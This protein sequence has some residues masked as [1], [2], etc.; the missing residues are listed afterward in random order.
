M[1][2]YKKTRQPVKKPKIR[3]GDTV[4]VRKGKDRGHVG[5]VLKVIPEEGRALVQGANRVFRHTRPNEKNPHGGRVHKEV[6]IPLSNLMLVGAD[7]T[8]SRVGIKR[9]TDGKIVRVLKKTGQ[10]LS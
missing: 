3:K 1:A 7:R 9:G 2:K 8:P 5:E 10:E 4:L 6:A